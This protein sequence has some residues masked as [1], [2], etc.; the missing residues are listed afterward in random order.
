MKSLSVVAWEESR[1][2][3]RGA[4]HLMREHR[5]SRRAA[6]SASLFTGVSCPLPICRTEVRVKQMR[7]TR[8]KNK[9]VTALLV[10]L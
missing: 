4:Q 2:S 3:V 8:E 10:L 5:S 7:D 9:E 6:A 1:V